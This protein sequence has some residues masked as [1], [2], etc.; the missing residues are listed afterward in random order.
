MPLTS[1]SSDD[2][3]EIPPSKDVPKERGFGEK[4]DKNEERARLKR[5]L[6]K[7]AGEKVA[8]LVLARIVKP[9]GFNRIDGHWL[10]NV[11]GMGRY[12]VNV[13]VDDKEDTSILGA[14]K[15]AQS[16]FVV[17]DGDEILKMEQR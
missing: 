4:R 9:L 16:Y 10:W 2:G 5:E 15:I 1:R 6:D 8:Q 13:R 17:A 7:D 3:D 12:R 14:T 11:F